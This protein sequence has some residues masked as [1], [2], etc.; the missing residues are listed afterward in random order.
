MRANGIGLIVVGCEIG[1]A[2]IDADAVNLQ[3]YLD[4]ALL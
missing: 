4:E 3:T 2:G 1:L